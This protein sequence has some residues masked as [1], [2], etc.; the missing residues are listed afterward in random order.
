MLNL[1][2]I[3]CVIAPIVIV[4]MI[5]SIRFPFFRLSSF[6]NS[7]HIFAKK[8]VIRMP[9]N[10]TDMIL[11][12]SNVNVIRM[13]ANIT[14]MI[15]HESN[16]IFNRV[17][18]VAF[19]NRSIC[20]ILNMYIKSIDSMLYRKNVSS[21]KNRMFLSIEDSCRTKVLIEFKHSRIKFVNTLNAF[22]FSFL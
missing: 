18:F 21:I 4:S 12:E 19:P 14:D 6:L 1:S 17:S 15:L 13:P 7:P 3:A 11:H 16:V 9:A 22:R 2:S 10:I 8:Y 5:I 20:S